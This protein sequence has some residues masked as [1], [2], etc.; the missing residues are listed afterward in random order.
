MAV[1]LLQRLLLLALL[2]VPSSTGCQF[3]DGID[4]D[5]EGYVIGPVANQTV[6]CEVCASNSKCVMAV[7]DRSDRICYAKQ[8][9]NSILA[10]NSTT[11]CLPGLAP[12]LHHPQL[13]V[14]HWG[15]CYNRSSEPFLLDGARA[16]QSLGF[17]TIKVKHA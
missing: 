17:R 9:A 7:F 8:S 16:V 5:D 2:F 12:S 15:G 3:V 6:C 14:T 4:A 11:A 13:G 10:K 1:T